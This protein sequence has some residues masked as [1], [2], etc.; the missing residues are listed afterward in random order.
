M[1]VGFFETHREFFAP[2]SVRDTLYSL[3]PA[4]LPDTPVTRRD[5]AE[6]KAS[7]R[8]LDQGIG[9]VLHALHD[10]GL[11]ENTLVICTTDH[12][13][14]FPGAKATLFDRGT[15]V[16]MIVRGPGFT[17]GKVVDAPVSH[18][19]VFPTLC[20]LAGA[21]HPEWLQGSSLMPLVRGE[22]ESLHEAIFSETTYHA[23]YQPHRAIRTERWKYIRRFDEYP[24]PVLANCDDSDTKDLL[25]EAG[26]GD[27]KVPEEQ[28]YDLVLDPQEGQN[29]AGD[30][31]TAE[32]RAELR[33][34]ARGL[35]AGDR[36]PAAGGAGGAARGGDRQRAVAGLARRPGADRQGR[37]HGRSIQVRQVQ[38]GIGCAERVAAL[39]VGEGAEAA[40]V[41]AE[42]PDPGR[43]RRLEALAEDGVEE[44]EADEDAVGDEQRQLAVGAG[45]QL[46]L[47][48]PHPVDRLLEAL[49]RGQLA[50]VVDLLRLEAERLADRL[51][52]FLGPPQ[53]ARE[54]AGDPVLAQAGAGGVRLLDALLGQPVALGVGRRLAAAV[55]VVDRL[56]VA[57]EERPHSAA[58]AAPATTL[59]KFSRCLVV[60]HSKAPSQ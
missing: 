53:G 29:L 36:G 1:S 59:T 2:T 20:D 57:E 49:A 37:L 5:M 51:R 24:H 31:G 41:G 27:E 10:F 34:A 9:A 14:A 38:P 17:G 43:H 16:M 39:A 60:Q 25:V 26:W 40:V 28:L 7:A 3:P 15:G 44:E 50:D 22:V 12:G 19:D 42:V 6:F 13:I 55:G 48:P 58:G 46:G 11:V 45:L 54:Q 21:E 4:N 30:P 47:Q 18:L 33:G 56:A 35:D 23:A 32:V 52:R 8:S